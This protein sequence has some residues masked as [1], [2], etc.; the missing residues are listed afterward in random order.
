MNPVLGVLIRIIQHQERNNDKKP[1]IHC[2]KLE[3]LREQERS[4]VHQEWQ[5]ERV[6]WGVM[7]A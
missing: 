5:K 4:N 7:S 1:I 2:E 6:M 3:V